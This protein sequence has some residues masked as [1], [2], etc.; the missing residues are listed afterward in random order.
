MISKAQLKAAA[1]E[2]LHRGEF[3][4]A[5]EAIELALL[6]GAEGLAESALPAP[7]AAVFGI[8]VKPVNKAIVDGTDR[9]LATAGQP[10]APP[11]PVPAPVAAAVQHA[12]GGPVGM[13]DAAASGLAVPVQP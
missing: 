9:A 8:V 13:L 4:A 6:T 11:S 3:R 5:V 2:L 10:S 12:Q 7:I 1:T